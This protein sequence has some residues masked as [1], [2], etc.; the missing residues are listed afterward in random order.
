MA[1]AA[2]APAAT[3]AGWGAPAGLAD[4]HRPG[5]AMLD[6]QALAS[7]TGGDSRPGPLR[8]AAHVA[9]RPARG[10]G[11]N[12]VGP[13][14]PAYH[15]HD[16]AAGGSRAV[17]AMRPQSTTRPS[18]D[19]PYGTAEQR[20]LVR[21]LEQGSWTRQTALSS[22]RRTAQVFDVDVDG[23]GTAVAVWSEVAGFGDPGVVRASVRG[24]GGR[25]Q[26]AEA[27][28]GPGA[29]EPALVAGPAGAL[30]AWVTDEPGGG[31]IWVAA[32]PAGGGWE[33]PRRLAASPSAPSRPALALNEHG[34]A[35]VAWQQDGALLVAGRGRD[36]GW[37]AA[38]PVSGAVV[39][40]AG[41][42]SPAAWAAIDEAG[43]VLVAWQA[44]ARPG[45]VDV[46]AATR[47]AGGAWRAPET[48]SL[49]DERGAGAPA[50][51]LRDGRAVVVW[52]QPRGG[53]GAIVM[54]REAVLATGAWSAPE[55]VSEPGEIAIAPSLA[56]DSR[57]RAVTVYEARRAGLR[58][59]EH[60]AAPAP[61][62]SPVRL[63]T[64]QLLINQRISQ[65][66]LRRA[67]AVVARLD[68][69]LTDA[70]VRLGSLTERPF[71]PNVAIAGFEGSEVAD[72]GP[73]APVRVAP[74][75][76]RRVSLELSARQLLINQRIS[77]AAVRRS[78]LTRRRLDLG[79]TG[80]DVRDGAITAA[81]LAPG[82]AVASADA[83]AAPL[84]PPHR[85]AEPAFPG[86]GGRVRLTREQLV[87]NQRIAQAAVRRANALIVQLEGGFGAEDFRPGSLGGADL[88]PD[89]R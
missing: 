2:P 21:V 77:Q 29:R 74:A 40:H 88:T 8:V 30:A 46:V 87:I 31:A 16:L 47:P 6:D 58:V 22:P 13:L 38:E 14:G 44:R 43:A 28:S 73:T 9:T 32:R 45:T 78:V 53:S 56:M 51:A 50:I 36:G 20:L 15:A 84:V 17:L 24:P 48:V 23:S 55:R 25:W 86:A 61:P 76:R 80:E 18:P 26:D 82:L 5:V 52:S 4:G 27:L 63:S 62:R 42:N 1:V 72:P 83:A 81:H 33:P 66:A 69:G 12:V 10:A 68:E 19:T 54:A 85:L 57:G 41:I 7:W 39:A 64:E 59:A 11:W 89:A 79:L 71:G 35:L 3:A 37:R 67:N 60:P 49:P 34:E 70:D 75:A 65:A